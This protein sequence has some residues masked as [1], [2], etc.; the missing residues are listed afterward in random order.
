MSGPTSWHSYPKLFAIGHRALAELLMDDVV[1]RR[2]VVR[3]LPE[4]YKDVLAQQQFIQNQD[5]VAVVE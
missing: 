5:G 2:G 4:W 1:V 3:G